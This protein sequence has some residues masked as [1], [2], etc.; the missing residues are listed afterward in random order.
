[1]ELRREP[2]RGRDAIP[3]RL[4]VSAGGMG[5][6]LGHTREQVPGEGAGHSLISVPLRKHHHACTPW[7]WKTGKVRLLFMSNAR[8]W[9]CPGL[10]TTP[11]WVGSMDSPGSRN[12]VARGGKVIAVPGARD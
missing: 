3:L 10:V 1:M 7:S 8:I 5:S 9:E 6:D 2:I 11:A 12:P 4:A